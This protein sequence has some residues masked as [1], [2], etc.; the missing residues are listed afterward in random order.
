MSHTKHKVS[1][2]FY[3]Q[4]A[5][6]V[7]W[8]WGFM[9]VFCIPMKCPSIYQI[10]SPW[11]RCLH[12]EEDHLHDHRSHHDHPQ[13]GTSQIIIELP[14][15]RRFQNIRLPEVDA[16]LSHV[17]DLRSICSFRIYEI[18]VKDSPPSRTVKSTQKLVSSTLSLSPSFTLQPMQKPLKTVSF[19]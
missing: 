13:N 14:S 1:Y 19:Y 11:R 5:K 3:R 18:E 10:S 8:D 2:G 12:P 4:V 17:Q 16:L 6:H 7:R 9:G 15:S